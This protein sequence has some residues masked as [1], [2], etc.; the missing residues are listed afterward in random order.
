ME[1]CWGNADEYDEDIT[2]TWK[3]FDGLL[4][5]VTCVEYAFIDQDSDTCT[6]MIMGLALYKGWCESIELF[7]DMRFE[8]RN[9]TH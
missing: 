1:K 9:S 8:A 2:M 4:I 3:M 5:K 6:T 7:K